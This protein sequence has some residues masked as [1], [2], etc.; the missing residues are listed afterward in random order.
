M[1]LFLQ[2]GK[3]TLWKVEEGRY[4]GGNSSTTTLANETKLPYLN[5]FFANAYLIRGRDA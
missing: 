5:I 1:Q 4:Y 3:Y 2:D